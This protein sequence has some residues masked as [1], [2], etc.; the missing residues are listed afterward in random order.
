MALLC[1]LSLSLHCLSPNSKVKYI[2]RK[3]LIERL[4][5]ACVRAVGNSG[6]FCANVAKVPGST[7]GDGAAVP[8]PSNVFVFDLL[9]YKLKGQVQPT[10]KSYRMSRWRMC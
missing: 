7:P 4:S 5:G 3:I 2:F 1:R 9:C 10:K 8:S 6:G